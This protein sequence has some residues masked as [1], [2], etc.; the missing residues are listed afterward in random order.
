LRNG[1]LQPGYTGIWPKISG[2]KEPAVDFVVQG[3]EFHGVP[4]LVNLYGIESPGLTASMTLA[5]QVLRRLSL[6]VRE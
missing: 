3:P 6:P 1:A 2:P 4:G 5:E